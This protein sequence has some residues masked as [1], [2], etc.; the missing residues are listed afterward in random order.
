VVLSAPPNP[1]QVFRGP[2]R[3]SEGGDKRGDKGRK[4]ERARGEKRKGAFL[5]FFTI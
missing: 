5:H 2:L 1:D 4:K 3:C